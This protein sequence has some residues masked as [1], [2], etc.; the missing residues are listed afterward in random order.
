MSRGHTNN[1]TKLQQLK[2]GE[3]VVK[4]QVYTNIR[5]RL[6]AQMTRATMQL[7]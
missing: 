1:I 4:A 5:T 2:Q 3:T 7:H 6:Y